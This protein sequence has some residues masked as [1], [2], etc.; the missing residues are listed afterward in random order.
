MSR[1]HGAWPTEEFKA[2]PE[3]TQIDF[4]RAGGGM[5]DWRVKLGES[6]AKHMIEKKQSRVKENFGHCRIG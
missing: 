5:K 2:L 1:E 6:I 4:M 3:K